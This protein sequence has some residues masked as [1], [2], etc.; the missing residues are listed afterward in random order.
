MAKTIGLQQRKTW[1]T[2]QILLAGWMNILALRGMMRF[3]DSTAYASSLRQISDVTL[4]GP[5]IDHEMIGFI[6]S[7]K[8]FLQASPRSSGLLQVHPYV[9][10]RGSHCFGQGNN[11]LLVFSGM[12]DEQIRHDYYAHSR[13]PAVANGVSRT[14]SHM[15]EENVQK[16]SPRPHGTED[17]TVDLRSQMVS[18]EDSSEYLASVRQ[19]S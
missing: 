5:K 10:I 3:L 1:G 17:L 15:T 16:R 7:T 9:P 11:E 19:R 4:S 2:A 6:D 14:K 18:A 13:G 12:R 8:D